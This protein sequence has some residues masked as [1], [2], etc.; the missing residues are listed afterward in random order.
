MHEY[1]ISDLSSLAELI[2]K[3]SADGPVKII[4]HGNPVA[5]VLSPEMYNAVIKLAEK[6]VLPK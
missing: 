1:T 4:D 3:Q 5:Y 2:V 6:E